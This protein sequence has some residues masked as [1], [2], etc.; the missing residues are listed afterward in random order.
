MQY[1]L[2]SEYMYAKQFWVEQ[3]ACRKFD[4]NSWFFLRTRFDNLFRDF[5]FPVNLGGKSK[6]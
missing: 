4:V 1:T 6:T 3:A 5:S 2:N